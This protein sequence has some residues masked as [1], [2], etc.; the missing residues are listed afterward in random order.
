[1]GDCSGD[2]PLVIAAANGDSTAVSVLLG[3]G[4]GTFQPALSFAA[5]TAPVS[6][7]VGDI[8]GDGRPDLA[9]ANDGVSVVL[10][11]GDGTFQPAQGF[12]DGNSPF[13]VG[14]GALTGGGG[15]ER[16]VGGRGE[17]CGSG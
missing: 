12:S 5:G 14:V 4:D 6:V 16:G 13:F 2:L 15:L 8:N 7:A 17:R 3:N 1:M 10:G 9:V 11:N